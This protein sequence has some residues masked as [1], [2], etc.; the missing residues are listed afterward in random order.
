VIG[1]LS[2]DAGIAL[3]VPGFY[4]CAGILL[5]TGVTA[6][7]VGLYRGRMP[8]AL[9]FSLTCLAATALTLALAAGYQA[10]S[11]AGAVEAMR[12]TTVA[13][14]VGLAGL[15]AF[16]A[17][18]TG[19]AHR[20]R[21]YAIG[22]AIAAVFIAANLLLPYGQRFS[23]VE[24]YGWIH[25]PWGESLFVLDGRIGAW[26]VA[27]RVVSI[28]VVAWCVW[29]LVEI[30]RGG[31][32]RD[33][34]VLAIYLVTLFAATVQGALIDLGVLKTFHAIPI[35]LV[36]LATLMS[37]N[38]AVQ[39]RLH[40]RDLKATATK[41]RLE[42]ERRR[43][44]EARLRERAYAD[45]LTGLPNRT[46]MQER[47]ATLIEAG[48]AESHGA[49]LICDLDHFKVINNA[50]GHEVGDQLLREV[51]ARLREV[52]GDRA[53]VARL[54][55]NTFL[56][57][58]EGLHGEEARAGEL[59]AALARDT[60]GAIERPGQFGAHSISLTTSIGTATFPA[61]GLDPN[62]VIGRA[63]LALH[64]A[65]RLGRNNIQASQPEDRHDVEARFRLIDGLRRAVDAHELV[66]HYQPQVDQHGHV[67][68]AEAL[69][70][71][72]SPTLGPVSPGAFI[73]IAEETGLIHEMGEWSLHTACDQLAAWRRARAGFAGPLSVNVSPWQLAHPEFVDRLRGIVAEHR[74]GPGDL[75]LEITESAVMLDTAEVVA[76][77]NDVR[78]MGINVALDDFG[79]GYSSLALIK[80]LPLDAIKID[81]SF[82]RHL[83]QGAN[84][85][86]T[87][88]IVAIGEELRLRVVAE[89]VESQAERASLIDLG[90]T[91]FQGYLFARPM[92]GP[93]FVHWAAASVAA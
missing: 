36:G 67:I 40:N 19:A 92:A 13:G 7:L 44:A 52:A 85:H 45:L 43:D 3:V 54:G 64:R 56:M 89:G 72:N 24:S 42:N 35:A 20:P 17:I 77:L 22:A 27:F 30:G 38:L 16:V 61:R 41:L 58:L 87:R 74:L 32:R 10:D 33:A 26:N 65:K 78:G 86:L 84:R 50:L 8:L 9:A 83:D 66:L 37:A 69:M 25:M 51:A 11:V 46:F 70:R 90:C 2:S 62:G 76:K 53:S 91:R 80:D 6:A 82:V 73:P 71:W 49:A 48:P 23:V 28:A 39:L 63:D 4:V 68:G 57:V 1:Q 93:D 59:I 12:W 79:T 34:V 5:Y 15:L 21:I 18:Y 14:N 31:R 81:Q 88:V 75:T 60:V 47:I 55:G 29:R